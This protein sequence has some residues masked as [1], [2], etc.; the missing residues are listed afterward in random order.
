[1]SASVLGQQVDRLFLAVLLLDLFFLVPVVVAI[2]RFSFRYRR[3]SHADR[4]PSR[5]S[6]VVLETLFIGVPLV[7]GLATFAWSAALYVRMRLPPAGAMEIDVVGQQWMWKVQHPQGR[8]E[9]DEL[10]VPAGVPIRLVL[11]SEDVIH[12]FFVPAFRMKQDAVPG[13]YTDAWFTAT[14]PGTYRLFCAEYCGDRHSRMDGLVTVMTPAAYADW[15]AQGS[16]GRPGTSM[17]AR[18]RESFQRHGCSG[19]HHPD[20]SGIGPPLTGVFGGPV[21]LMDG[22][23]VTADENYVRDS[24]LLPQKDVAAGYA[25]VMPSFAGQIDEVELL[26]IVAYVKSLA[27]AATSA[28][29]ERVR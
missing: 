28:R 9:I 14:R 6:P 18:G 1:M 17:A 8:Q 12:S 3:G 4:S 5:V 23:V 24:I 20:A 25:P 11:A 19:C 29:A 21:P 7:L 2:L 16:T 22:R 13:R 26:E 10:H 15:L 27:P